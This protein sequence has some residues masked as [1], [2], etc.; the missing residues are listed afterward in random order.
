[1]SGL[2]PWHVQHGRARLIDQQSNIEADIAADL[3]RRHQTEALID[4]RT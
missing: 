2:L 4:A 3:G 1:M